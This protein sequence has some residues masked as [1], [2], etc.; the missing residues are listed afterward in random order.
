MPRL[1]RAR[2]ATLTAIGLLA[3]GALAQQP[4]PPA[5]NAPKFATP[6]AKPALFFREPW[7][8]PRALDA[9]TEWDAAF[10]VTPAAVTNP[11]LELKVYDPNAKRIPEYAKAPP[12]GSLPRDW[13][14]TSCVILSG[15]NQ[16]PRPDKVVHGDPTDPPNLWT[17]TCGPIAVTLRH[18]TS[19]VDLSGF[20]K[21]R[22]VTRVSGFHVVRPLLKLAD[23]TWLVGDHAT[24]ADR[25]G[26]GAGASIDFLESEVP[27]AT[28]RWIRLDIN[29]VVTRG[30]MLEKADLSNVEEVGFADLTPGTGHGWGGF[31]N[32]GKIEVYGKPVSRKAS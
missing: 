26:A 6:A 9:S 27:L 4:A 13:I 10:P 21:L 31:V 29:R 3:V 2:F 12:Q 23:G 14:G 32:V 1:R 25:A 11:D 16:E 7:R 30:T 24:G 18:R 8:Q 28:V 19:N 22:W 20:A 15:Y 17:G 5:A